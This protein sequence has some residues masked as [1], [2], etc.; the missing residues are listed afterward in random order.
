VDVRVGLRR[1]ARAELPPREVE[2]PRGLC[3]DV[4]EGDLDHPVTRRG[5]P[6]RLRGQRPQLELGEEGPRLGVGRHL[7]AVQRPP[8]VVLVHPL[9]VHPQR[10]V[11][12]V[13]QLLPRHRRVG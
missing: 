13:D 5:A 1:D 7:V 10:A 2:P 11:H 8:D 12:G 4:V 9:V 3:E 6:Q